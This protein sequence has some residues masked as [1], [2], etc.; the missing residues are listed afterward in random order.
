YSAFNA[1]GSPRP[2]HSTRWFVRAWQRFATIVRGGS[3][4]A[5]NRHLVRLGMP[6]L[7][8]AASNRARTYR[9]HGVGNGLARPRVAMVW[10]PQTISNPYIHANRPAKY[11]PG[12]QYVDW[13][14]ADIYSKFASPGVRLALR[15]FQHRYRHYPMAIGEYS[16]WD[17]DYQGKFVHWLFFW[18]RHHARVRML[19]NYRSVTP[20]SAFD[21]S[22]YPTAR[23]K[24]SH[25]LD[26]GHYMPYAPGLKPKHH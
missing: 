19:V 16:P 1:D 20:K 21:I 14:A 3:V 9:V 8:R 5:I 26:S 22:R 15:R 12:R 11:W 6:R 24:L 25:L 18:A 4:G 7:L 2:G 23:L 13:V 17:N 10:N